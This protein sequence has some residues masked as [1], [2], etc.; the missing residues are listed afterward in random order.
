[1][2]SF[3]RGVEMTQKFWDVIFLDQKT[4]LRKKGIQQQYNIEEKSKII[5]V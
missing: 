1:M 4:A 2:N 3:E 5:I